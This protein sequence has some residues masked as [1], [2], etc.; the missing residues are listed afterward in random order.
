MNFEI[1]YEDENIVV[2]NKA[3]GLLSVPYPGFSGKTLEDFLEQ[4]MRKMGTW[5]KQHRPF[6]VHRLD[7]DTSGVMMFALDERTQKKMM[8]NWQTI[9]TERSYIALAENPR[10]SVSIP[11]DGIIDKP[12]SLNSKN[13]SGYVSKNL[14]GEKRDHNKT[15]SAITHYK[16]LAK[17]KRYTLFQLDLETGRKNQIRAH[18]SSVGYPLAGDSNYGAKTDPFGRLCLHARSLEFIHPSTGEK[19]KF[20]VEEPKEWGKMG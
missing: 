4:R 11:E 15:V 7:R 14:H 5:K 18:L 9:V 1:L 12:I 8:D 10:N 6:A 13:H 3:S 16:I 20:E 17:G 19:M 2:V